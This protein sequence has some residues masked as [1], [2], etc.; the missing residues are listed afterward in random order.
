MY[1]IKRVGG[2]EWVIQRDGADVGPHSFRTYGAARVYCRDR[3]WE[4]K[5]RP[6]W[7]GEDRAYF[8]GWFRRY[9]INPDACGFDRLT[10]GEMERLAGEVTQIKLGLE[11]P[12]RQRRVA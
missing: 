3:G 9:G 2:G 10:I 1:R 6:G 5:E 11:V 12:V 8:Y 7:E 4:T